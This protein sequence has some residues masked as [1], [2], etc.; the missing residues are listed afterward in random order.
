MEKQT[1][2]GEREAPGGVRMRQGFFSKR[3]IPV[4]YE[5]QGYIYFYSKRYRFLPEREKRVIERIAQA[6]GG[7]YAAAVLEFVTTDHGKVQVEMH[8]HMSERTLERYVREYYILFA[9]ALKE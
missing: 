8:H 7:E 2:A 4:G 3:S 6:A 1:A 5:M 9:K